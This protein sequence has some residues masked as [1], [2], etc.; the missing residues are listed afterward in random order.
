MLKS[1][2]R[3]R[4]ELKV[5]SEV[6]DASVFE[7]TADKRGLKLAMT[8]EGS[9]KPINLNTLLAAPP[10]LRSDESP[11]DCGLNQFKIINGVT[12]FT[13]RGITLSELAAWLTSFVG[14]PVVEHIGAPT[15]FDVH[16]E[17]KLSQTPASTGPSIE[18]APQDLSIFVA[19]KEQLGID[20]I[21]GKAPQESIVIDSVK[22]PS[23]N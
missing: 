6:R 9:C 7:L 14:R 23:A 20:L 19:V 13:A 8:K 2:L 10:E 21:P 22:R 3:D 4:F 15:L 18:P 11:P 17:F 12:V 5:H 16:L 1:L